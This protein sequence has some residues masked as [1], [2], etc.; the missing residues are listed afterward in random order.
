MLDQSVASFLERLGSREP[1]PGGGSVAALTGAL[2]A[3]LAAMV[4]RLTIGKQRYAEHEAELQAVLAQA[5]AL[6]QQLASLV[7]QDVA[8]YEGLSAAY[9]LPRESQAE[10]EARD[11]AI[12]AALQPATETPLRIAESAARVVDLAP[13]VI[14]KGSVVAVSDA[15]MAALLGAAALQSAALNVHINLGS[16]SDGASADAYRQRLA[17]AVAGRPAQAAALY[18]EVLERLQP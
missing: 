7:E 15:G 14:R 8:A 12:Q 5:D 6:R 3:A 13:V 9:K 10:Q 18:Q 4:C 1:T 2:A 17:D 16:L 11:Q